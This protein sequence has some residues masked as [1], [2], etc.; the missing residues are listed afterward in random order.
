MKLELEQHVP[1]VYRF[2]LRLTKDPH[3]A[4][5]L[6][7]DVFLRAWQHRHRLREPWAV[8][9]WLFRITA[10]LWKDE[11]RK[12]HPQASNTNP[13]DT[14]APELSPPEAAVAQENVRRALKA[15]DQLPERQQQVLYL[16][17]C[18]QMRLAEIVDVLQITYNDA[19]VILSLARK[20]LR[21][22]LSD[23]VQDLFR[24]EKRT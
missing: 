17:A 12:S 20:K 13:D 14:P 10:N 4:D 8:R 5:D 16:H 22:Q 15:L 1:R 24:T 6:T 3:R 2:A 11:L 9:V 7:Q 18:E 23:I 19:K 21:H